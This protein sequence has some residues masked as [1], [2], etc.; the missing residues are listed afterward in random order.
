MSS[1]TDRDERE[2]RNI[3]TFE[4]LDETFEALEKAFGGGVGFASVASV[5]A[6]GGGVGFTKAAEEEDEEVPCMPIKILRP[7]KRSRRRRPWP[8][9][10]LPRRRRQTVWHQISK[11]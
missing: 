9:R 4:A 6:F 8:R 2:K 3:E 1:R 7:K 10:R 11:N 5:Q